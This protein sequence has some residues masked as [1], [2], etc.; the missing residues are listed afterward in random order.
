MSST[1]SL[2]VS[3]VPAVVGRSVRLTAR[4]T[5]EAASAAPTGTVVF[6]VG[7]AVLGRVPLRGGTAVL[8]T[9]GLQL[10][11]HRLTASYG[12]DGTYLPSQSSAVTQS[13]TRR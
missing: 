3:P 10:G 5:G 7:D 8:V 12:G 13:I 2:S 1:V 11:E 4:V 9:L 6:L